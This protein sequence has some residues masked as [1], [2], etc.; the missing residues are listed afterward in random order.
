MVYLFLSLLPSFLDLG[1][2]LWL[3]G[4]PSPSPS[5]VS[6]TAIT[7]CVR[8][9][10]VN[11]DLLDLNS[12]IDLSNSQSGC[13]QVHQPSFCSKHLSVLFCSS[14][15]YTKIDFLSIMIIRVMHASKFSV[16]RENM[17]S[18][19]VQW[20]TGLSIVSHCSLCSW[21]TSVLWESVEQETVL[22]PGPG[23]TVTVLL[24]SL[25][26]SVILV[27]ITHTHEYSSP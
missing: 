6:S 17:S 21:R 22:P 8:Q 13:P 16:A 12:H 24:F 18:L 9:V 11:G 20:V 27:S 5:H 25:V 23:P 26:T 19:C 1:L 2:P 10:V 14:H 7:A 15:I 3:G 4:A